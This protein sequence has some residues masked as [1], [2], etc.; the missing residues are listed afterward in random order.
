MDT[1][2][3]PTRFPI[4]LLELSQVLDTEEKADLQT[5]QQARDDIF[6]QVEEDVLPVAV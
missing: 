5:F 6:E 1:S 3:Y 4:I 2:L